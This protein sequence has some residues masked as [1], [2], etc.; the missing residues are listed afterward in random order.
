[1]DN[2]DLNYLKEAI[3]QRSKNLQTNNLL[4][5]II[6]RTKLQLNKFFVNDVAKENENQRNVLQV[7][8]FFK[9][10]LELTVILS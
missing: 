10:L 7:M 9:Y 6:S 1:M 3:I 8:N 5:K 2:T 4:L